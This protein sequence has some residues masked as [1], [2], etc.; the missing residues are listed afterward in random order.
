M[1]PGPEPRRLE[2]YVRSLSPD[3]TRTP[4]ETQL[5]RLRELESSTED[6]TLSVTVWGREIG[7]STTAARTDAGRHV[8]DRIGAFRHWAEGE[9]LSLDPF[10]EPREVRSSVTGEN[11]TSLVLPVSCLA[12]YSDD[13][14]CHVAPYATSTA[15]CSVA[16]RISTLESRHETG[17]PATD[18]P[19][20][21]ATR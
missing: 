6:L 4:V 13:E 1:T 2:L 10:F 21:L 15:V 14:L 9:D 8:L 5:E 17:A 16:D 3:A 7:L 20:T 11:Y 12:E 18:E 19:A